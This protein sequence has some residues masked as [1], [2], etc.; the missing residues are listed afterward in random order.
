[1]PLKKGEVSEFTLLGPGRALLVVC[2]D[3][4]PGDLAKAMALR[5]QVR[6]ELVMIQRRQLPG[7]WRK[8]NLSR[9]GFEPGDRFS[10]ETSEDEEAE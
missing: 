10:V 9:L 1:M 3:R 5:A 4:S 2:K 7:A 8:W 6:D